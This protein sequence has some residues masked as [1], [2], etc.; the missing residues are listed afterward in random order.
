LNKDLTSGFSVIQ[1]SAG[2]SVY[3]SDKYKIT[4][5]A[6]VGIIELAPFSA[7]SKY[8]DYNIYKTTL[9]WGINI[10]YT[11]YTLLNLVNA[12]EKSAFNIRGGIY[13][14]PFN[15]NDNIEGHS[16]N[17]TIGIDWYANFLK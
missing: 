17:F 11:L 3:K 14:M 13:V 2:Y 10:D 7:R 16:F 12:K 15:I 9:I 1:L 6:G 4:P 8:E 5:F